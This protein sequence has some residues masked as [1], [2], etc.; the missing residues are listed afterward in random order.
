MIAIRT[1]DAWTTATITLDDGG[2]AQVFSTIADNAYD[3]AEEFVQW[4]DG[5]FG[6]TSSWSWSR[7]PLSGGALIA[8]LL[9]IGYTMTTNAAAQSIL[10]AAAAGGPGM[11]ATLWTAPAGSIAPPT[12]AFSAY[13]DN[14]FAAATTRGTASGA[15][16]ARVA[17]GGMT[18]FNM[19]VRWPAY[20][21]DMERIR[22]VQVDAVSP[23]E[24]YIYGGAYGWIL[25]SL[26]VITLARSGLK[27]WRA[28]VEVRA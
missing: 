16:V 14:A 23:R 2:G 9:P 8:F 13:L 7:D 5:T 25:A 6:D 17:I 20:A 18:A 10:G 4:V 27:L 1:T 22:A 11:T 26:G 21:I 12:T 28:T 15:G 19:G 24:A 3:A